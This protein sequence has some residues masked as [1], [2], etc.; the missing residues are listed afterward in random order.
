MN[1]SYLLDMPR[2]FVFTT[3]G[4]IPAHGLRLGFRD[5]TDITSLQSQF[6]VD[7]TDVSAGR[8]VFSFSNRVP[9]THS[10]T[11]IYFNDGRL[12]SI[13]VDTDSGE[14]SHAVWHDCVPRP[15]GNP[16]IPGSNDQ[17]SAAHINMGMFS[18]TGEGT[19]PHDYGQ[20]E[21]LALICDLQTGI[22]I[23]DIIC[24]LR[25]GSLCITIKVQETE[26]G[27]SVVFTNESMQIFNHSSYTQ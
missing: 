25:D 8:V 2:S 21:S 3:N 5:E 15:A 11:G 16:D 13:A 12:T 9:D 27:A 6:F 14:D 26:T 17:S 24:A 10:I 22:S 20:H 23:A 18:D 1:R 7:L 19:R 4:V